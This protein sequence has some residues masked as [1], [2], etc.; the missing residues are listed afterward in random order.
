MKWLNLYRDPAVADPAGGAASA[1]AEPPAAAPGATPDAIKPGSAAASVNINDPAKPAAPAFALPDAWKDKPYLKG[2]DSMEKVFAM[3]DGAQTLIGKNRVAVPGENATQ[4][5]LDAY[6]EAVGRPKTAAEYKFEGA[7][8]ADPKFLPKVQA[9]LHEAG[10]SSKQAGIVWSKVN[11]A[12]GEYMTEKGIADTQQN[13][14]FTKLATDTF[15]AERDAVLARGK[16]L[17]TQLASPTMKKYIETLPNE[18]LVV[19][20]DILRNADKKYISPDGPHK[21]PTMGTESPDQLR[22]KAR[23]LMEKQ[24]K[25]DRMSQEFNNMQT[26][27][28]AIYNKIRQATVR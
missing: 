28:D 16:E 4:A 25:V 15:G 10:L 27:I 26:E 23:E 7:D 18:S 22:A 17:I 12:L 14:D 1:I 13:T 19:L 11:A 20:A 5:E 3:L 6:Y 21:P 2:V 24:G 8:K 9:A